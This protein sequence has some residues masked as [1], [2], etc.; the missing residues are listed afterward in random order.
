V[1][2]GEL[3][4]SLVYDTDGNNQHQTRT[5]APYQLLTLLDLVYELKFQNRRGTVNL[6]HECS[7]PAHNVPAERLRP[8]H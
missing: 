8:F 4:S 2:R 7:R 5:F 6:E 3:E 1:F